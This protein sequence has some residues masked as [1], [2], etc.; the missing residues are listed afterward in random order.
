MPKGKKK[1]AKPLDKW[2][3]KNKL[4][5][6]LAA[7]AIIL[8]AVSAYF[9][10]Q[11]EK[12]KLQAVSVPQDTCRQTNQTTFS[13]YKH[14]LQ[15]TT[16][17]QGPESA[18][19][20][21]RA[22]YDQVPYVKSQCHQLMHIVGRQAFLQYNDDLGAT[23]SHGD[24]FC[25]SGYY[26]GALEELSK[27]RGTEIVSEANSV[28]ADLRNSNVSS[29]DHFNCVHGLGHGFMYI[30]GQ[31]LMKSLKACDTLTDSFERTSCYGGVFMQ[32]IMNVQTPDREA[33]YASPY[34]KESDPM[35]PC[36]ALDDRYKEQCYLMQTSY[37]LQ[38]EN[39]DFNK[40][41]ALC[42][43]IEKTYRPTCYTSVGRDASGQSV[44]DVERTK[45][46]CLLGK[47]HEA[48]SYCINGAAKDFVSYYHDDTKA[49]Q[50][51]DSLPDNLKA[52]CQQVVTSYYAGF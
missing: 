15:R 12:P 18:V 23:F 17:N 7:L 45:N 38:V 25:W 43:A 52:D 40:V 29:F 35:Y 47:D 33:G 30:L 1:T 34:L 8:I 27:Q 13:C 5:A 31:D 32:N 19:A 37:A 48:Q 4:W 3:K 28:C 36:T 16:T 41:F 49:R 6:G 9:L 14:L 44:S 42:A 22:S 20:L 50:L 51:C 26:H 10:M 39:Y 24:Q 46:T 11:P 21:L 2:L